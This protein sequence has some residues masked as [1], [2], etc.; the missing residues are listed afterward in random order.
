VKNVF[1][2]LSVYPYN[3]SNNPAENQITEMLAYV[4]SLDKR[5]KGEFLR[6]FVLGSADVKGLGGAK[7]ETQVA[8]LINTDDPEVKLYG[9]PDM[10]VTG[11]GFTVFI[12]NKLGAGV[13]DTRDENGI[14]GNQVTKYLKILADDASA[15]DLRRL[16]LIDFDDPGDEPWFTKETRKRP[17][18]YGMFTFLSW[19]DVSDFFYDYASS[20]NLEEPVRTV[21]KQFNDFLYEEKGMGTF[22]GIPEFGEENPFTVGK[23][24][25][26]LKGLL[27]RIES[28]IVDYN[29]KRLFFRIP[30]KKMTGDVYH[31]WFPIVHKDCVNHKSEPHI[32]LALF[33]KRFDVRLTIPDKAPAKFWLNFKSLVN[34]NRFFLKLLNS[35]REKVPEVWFTI[36]QRHDRGGQRLVRDGTV[37]FKIDVLTGIDP[38][39]ESGSLKQSEVI[40]WDVIKSVNILH[41]FPNIELAF[42]VPYYTIESGELKYRER[43]KPYKIKPDETDF[44]KE[45]VRSIKALMPL[46]YAIYTGDTN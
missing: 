24:E 46:F 1:K 9:I 3:P 22:R 27:D 21:L 16:I 44:P 23:A 28:D 26:I 12:E 33:E 7:V 10:A 43:Y 4:L 29:Y 35:I 14:T 40:W 11:E 15:K 19:H 34:N 17:D 5:L 13:G 36:Y 6:A 39:W 8:K 2:T 42:Y 30:E 25:S 37:E 31:R 32:S 38:I 20:R 18:L 45:V 41:E